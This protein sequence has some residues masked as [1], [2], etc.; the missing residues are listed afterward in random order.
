M[1]ILLQFKQKENL[2]SAYNMLTAYYFQDITHKKGLSLRQNNTMT[3]QKCG[4]AFENCD[5]FE[6]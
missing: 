6:M 3:S 2:S 1:W 4:R 5:D